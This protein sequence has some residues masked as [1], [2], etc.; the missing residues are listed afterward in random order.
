[1]VKI[2]KKTRKGYKRTWKFFGM[3][4]FSYDKKQKKA[5]I[6]KIFKKYE[7]NPILKDMYN[8][9]YNIPNEVLDIFQNNMSYINEKLYQ[10]FSDDDKMIF[11]RWIYK[12]YAGIDSITED[13][14][15]LIDSKFKEAQ[16]IFSH[17]VNQSDIMEFLIDDKKIKYI[18][19]T[20]LCPSFNS[21]YSEKESRLMRYYEP[22]H[23]FLLKEYQLQDFEPRDGQTILDCGGA[24]GDTAILFK[25][26]YP[27][28]KVY[29]FECDETN[30]K[31]IKT[32]LQINNYDDDVIVENT[33]LYSK[34]GNAFFSKKL[35]KIVKTKIDDDCF[36]ITTLSIDDYCFENDIKNIGFIKFDIEGGEQEALKGAINTIKEQKPLL[37]IPIYHLKNDIYEITR[38]LDD[39]SIM[40]G[41]GDMNIRIKWTEKLVWGVDCVLF[42]RF[43]Q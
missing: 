18:S 11:I 25:T 14:F 5:L 15:N 6:E 28:S 37:A 29:S 39:M 21:N 10:K 42:V 4:I 26:L 32:N 33:F 30:F 16:Q 2:F 12:Y 35:N 1:M 20:P 34:T 27:H 17:R 19:N 40:M 22:V 13:E 8:K 38:F 23:A 9:F 7:Y 31:L 3:P 41:G 43:G 24:S 36:S